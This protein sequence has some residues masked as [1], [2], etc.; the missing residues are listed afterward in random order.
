MMN[1][2]DAILSVKAKVDYLYSITSSPLCSLILLIQLFYHTIFADTL[3][4]CKSPL[5]F[6]KYTLLWNKNSLL[7][8]NHSEDCNNFVT[9]L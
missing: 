5:T 7:S 2:L 1:I 8:S 6:G 4:K 3:S 9:K